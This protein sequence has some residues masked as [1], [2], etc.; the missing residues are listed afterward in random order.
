MPDS[1]ILSGMRG[2]TLAVLIAWASVASGGTNLPARSAKELGILKSYGE[3]AK[4]FDASVNTADL[5]RGVGTFV[6]RTIQNCRS[7]A[8]ARGKSS[9]SIGSMGGN[10]LEY[11]VLIALRNRNLTPA[12]WQAE[13][14]AV[15][16]A[17]N[18]VMLWSQ[19]HGPIII[20]CKT[21]LRERYK[22]ADLEALALQKTYPNAKY[23]LVTLDDDKQHVA[24]IRRKIKDGEILALQMIYDET[25][26]DELFTFLGALT[27]M[28]APPDA[29]RSGK[30]VR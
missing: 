10:W 14:K 13:F 1:A 30:S 12:Y 19:Q 6:Y 24:R 9:G 8:T 18:D 15:P 4:I 22:Q 16:N 3:S 21:S 11:A 2:L 20:S 5:D 27:L 26:L 25:N 7:N 29:L 17:F 28:D 23:F